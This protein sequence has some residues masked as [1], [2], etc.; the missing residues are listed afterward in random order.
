MRPVEHGVCLASGCGRARE[1]RTGDPRADAA[2]ERWSARG[3]DLG[4]DTRQLDVDYAQQG[5]F[6]IDLGY[7][8]L[9]HNISDTYQTPY[10]GAGTD[11][12]L[13]PSGWLKP[14][15]PQV[16]PNH[17]NDRALSPITGLAS[18][19]TRTGQV[20]PPDA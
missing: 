17:L 4:I 15:V 6:R 18:A 5:K 8:Q 1:R 11:L 3:A 20:A 7:D 13:L 10:I 2:H 9:R 14:N 19:V 16:N 12:L